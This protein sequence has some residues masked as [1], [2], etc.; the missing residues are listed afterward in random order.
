[1][2]H[3]IGLVAT[4]CVERGRYVCRRYPRIQTAQGAFCATRILP[5]AKKKMV[6]M[7]RHRGTGTANLL[8]EPR[9]IYNATPSRI[10]SWKRTSA[11]GRT[12]SR[13]GDIRGRS[14][15]VVRGGAALRVQGRP[16]IKG[17]SKRTC[18]ERRMAVWLE[19]S[20]WMGSRAV[21]SWR[22]TRCATGRERVSW[23]GGLGREMRPR[24]SA[25]R[26]TGRGRWA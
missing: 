3:G 25:N 1:V 14:F 6:T 22:I 23:T 20:L 5:S 4:Q 17:R 2:Y 8:E 24:G 18:Q 7:R 10:T 12:V 21:G 9:G 26:V 16:R 19:A 11:R 13:E 15:G